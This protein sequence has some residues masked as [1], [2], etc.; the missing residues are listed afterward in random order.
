MELLQSGFWMLDPARTIAKY[1]AFATAADADVPGFVRLEDWANA[2]PPLTLAA[3]RDLFETMIAEDRPGR[4]GWQVGGRTIDPHRLRCPTV[5]FVSLTDRIVPAATAADLADRRDVAAGHVGMI[6]GRKARN[7]LWT[8]IA[9][10][11][12]GLPRSR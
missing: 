4:G 8:P 5:E 11:I 3:G 6:V 7:G 10:W 9:D 1:E 2:G 12:A